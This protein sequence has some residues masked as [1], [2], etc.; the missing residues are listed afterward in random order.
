MKPLFLILKEPY[1]SMI[2]SGEKKEEYRDMTP[3]WYRRLNKYYNRSPFHVIFQHG[4]TDKR[5]I[6]KTVTRVR[7]GHGRPEWGAIKGKSYYVL[8]L[9]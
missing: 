4:Y 7:I 9:K 8:E 1:F 3:Y 5:R 6:E 2:E